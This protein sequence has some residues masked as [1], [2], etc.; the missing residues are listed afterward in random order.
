MD[1]TD[2]G[3]KC[4]ICGCTDGDC[5]QCIEKTGE[6]CYWVEE[7]LCSA[8]AGKSLFSGTY[9]APAVPEA[10]WINARALKALFE[11]LIS[12]WRDQGE[13]IGD[14]LY[15]WL[16]LITGKIDNESVFAGT[17]GQV[18]DMGRSNAEKFLAGKRI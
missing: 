9:Y 17:R 10:Q 13:A 18:Y 11:N 16:D 5:R 15:G 4:R 6:P 14:Y 8:C 2:K 1:K 7:D 3:R 12:T